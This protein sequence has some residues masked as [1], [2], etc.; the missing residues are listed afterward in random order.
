[1]DTAYDLVD[2][3]PHLTD[4]LST[5]NS[6]ECLAMTNPLWGALTQWLLG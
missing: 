1:M 6:L 2:F 4:V 5:V 3:Q